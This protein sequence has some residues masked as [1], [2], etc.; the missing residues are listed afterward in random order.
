MTNGRSEG[1]A[2]RAAAAKAAGAAS[3]EP[4]L[5]P[6]QRA[7]M[8]DLSLLLDVLLKTTSSRCEYRC[9]GATSLCL[10][11]C[12]VYSQRAYCAGCFCIVAHL[13]FVNVAR[14]VLASTQYC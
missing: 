9:A 8:A 2:R 14:H 13:S 5:T 6:R 12:A 4:G 7:R 1:I 11:S 3:A 10:L